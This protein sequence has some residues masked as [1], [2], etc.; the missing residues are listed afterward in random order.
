MLNGVVV[1]RRAL[2]WGVV[3]PKLLSFNF[4]VEQ[5]FDGLAICRTLALALHNH[6]RPL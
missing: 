3:N 6:G 4:N 1:E 5:W 2:Y